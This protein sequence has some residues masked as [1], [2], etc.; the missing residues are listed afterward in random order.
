MYSEVLK[1]F[2]SYKVMDIKKKRKRTD[3]FIWIDIL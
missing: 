2:K 1:I 3:E